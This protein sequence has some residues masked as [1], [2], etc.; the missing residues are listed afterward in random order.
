MVLN[1]VTAYTN[2]ILLFFLNYFFILLVL[3]N[4]A[5]IQW[6]NDAVQVIL[7]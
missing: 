6:F 3:F 7:N 5:V 1:A 2:F 4:D